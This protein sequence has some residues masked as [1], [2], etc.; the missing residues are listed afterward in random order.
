MLSNRHSY[1]RKGPVQLRNAASTVVLRLVNGG[2]QKPLRNI[3]PAAVLRGT[4]YG[5][6]L[7]IAFGS[8]ASAMPR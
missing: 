8:K 1:V 4:H 7:S 6:M 3:H 5:L 2:R